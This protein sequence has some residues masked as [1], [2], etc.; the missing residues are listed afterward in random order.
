MKPQ[1]VR[2]IDIEAVKSL[3]VVHPE[4]KEF[5]NQAYEWASN[6]AKYEELFDQ[7]W[8]TTVRK[9]RLPQKYVDAMAKCGKI[10][11]CTTTPRAGM[12]V[13]P[14][15]EDAKN[16][17][18]IIMAPDSNKMPIERK[19]IRY[20]TKVEIR[21]Q[22]MHGEGD[23]QFDFSAH[24]DQLEVKAK[25]RPFRAFYDSKGRAWQSCVVSMG[26][27]GGPDNAQG[28]TWI[29]LDFE[30]PPTVKVSSMIDNTRFVGPLRDRRIAAIE[31]LKRCKK[32]NVLINDLDLDKIDLEACDVDDEESIAFLRDFEKDEGPF[33]GEHYNYVTKERSLIEKTTKKL[34]VSW[35]RRDKWTHRNYAAH[36]G[37]LFYGSRVLDVKLADRYEALRK[38]SNTAAKLADDPEL[39]DQPISHDQYHGEAFRQLEGLTYWLRANKP[40]PLCGEKNFT[41]ADLTIIADASRWG[42]G[43]ISIARDGTVEFA[44]GKWPEHLHE[45]MARSTAAEPEAAYQAML[46][47]V[48]VNHKTVRFLTDH[49]AIQ[50][51][52]EAGRA[53]GYDVNLLVHRMNSHFVD[54]RFHVAH[55]PG[56][57]NPTDGIS[58]GKELTAD[59]L[60]LAKELKD[61]YEVAAV[62]R[63]KGSN[64]TRLTS[65]ADD[66]VT[67]S[68]NS[69]ES[70]S[71]PRSA[72]N[73]WMM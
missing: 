21:E 71:L 65:A 1:A 49:Q 69:L 50:F 59:D 29:L 34:E 2:R 11:P 55:L 56:K 28:V 40:V 72:D 38:F 68:D 35:E 48:H 17:D 19:K 46:R 5:F 27:C 22:G 6:P 41:D 14:R 61:E 58:R 73:T 44:R 9:A 10:E 39:W 30:R 32:I 15:Y 37:L 31:F 36:W 12:D 52:H 26:E 7:G 57:R 53:K 24:F 43:A 60:D 8:E 64:E 54:T 47:F 42:W 20:P 18:R 23:T 66:W 67:K 4:C 45:K 63:E 62:K 16:R 3:P 51:A 70:K 33:L 25:V 13:F